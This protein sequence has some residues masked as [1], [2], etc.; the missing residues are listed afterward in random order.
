MPLPLHVQLSG[1]A[2]LG[3]AYQN[4][5]SRL[6]V[7]STPLSNLGSRFLDSPLRFGSWAHLCERVGESINFPRGKLTLRPF[8]KERL[9]MS[10]LDGS[11]AVH[12]VLT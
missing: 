1:E 8:L 3:G 5:L 11:G 6:H 7:Q 9:M 12:T 2:P 4:V 10:G